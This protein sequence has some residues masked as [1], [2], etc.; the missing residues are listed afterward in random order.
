MLECA[1]C[2]YEYE[3]YS[4]YLPCLRCRIHVLT[5]S[6]LLNLIVATLLSLSIRLCLLVRLVSPHR[7]TRTFAAHFSRALPRHVPQH[8]REGTAGGGGLQAVR[9]YRQKSQR[10]VSYHGTGLFA[11]LTLAT[12]L[13]CSFV[14]FLQM[15]FMHG[16]RVTRKARIPHITSRQLCLSPANVS[17][18]EQSMPLPVSLRPVATESL[19]SIP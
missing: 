2:S 16:A 18:L 9:K 12:P 7:Q 13:P 4:L 14:L 1:R 10:G 8:Q 17:E 15:Y 3:G 5:R 19:L 11:R 6:C